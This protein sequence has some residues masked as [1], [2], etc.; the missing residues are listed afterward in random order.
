VTRHNIIIRC[1]LPSKHI[2]I[3]IWSFISCSKIRRLFNDSESYR[4]D[5]MSRAIRISLNKK[6]VRTSRITHRVS[7]TKSSRLVM[8]REIVFVYSGNRT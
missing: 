6:L 4:D 7:I 3:F 1:K 2:D 5:V 8:C